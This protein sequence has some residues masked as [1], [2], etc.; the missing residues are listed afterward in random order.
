M[1]SMRIPGHPGIGVGGVDEREVGKSGP[2]VPS[3]PAP[4]ISDNKG[5]VVV[6]TGAR[7]VVA[8]MEQSEADRA[9]RIQAVR[10]EIQT[11]QYAIDKDA[12]AENIVDDELARGA[13]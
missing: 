6:R 7:R 9:A 12:L 13:P 8:A 1:V 11:G 3:G 4:S 10:H 5:S 2:A